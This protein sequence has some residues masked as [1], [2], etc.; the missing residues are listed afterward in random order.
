VTATIF[1]EINELN[2]VVIA[3]INVPAQAMVFTPSGGDYQLSVDGTGPGS[4]TFDF[5]G[6]VF[7]D[8]GPYVP[9]GSTPTKISVTL[10][11]TL[12]AL[13]QDGTTAFIQKKDFDGVSITVDTFDIPEPTTAFLAL[14]SLVALS[15]TRRLG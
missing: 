3:P 2:G 8:L 14:L 1:V 4:Y 9:F 6:A 11:N 7:I 10:D 12:T 15:G 13:S 5:S